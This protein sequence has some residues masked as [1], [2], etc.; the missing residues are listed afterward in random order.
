[1]RYLIIFAHP[2]TNSFNHAIKE[3]VENELTLSGKKFSSR[4]LYHMNFD[5][6]LNLQDI[7]GAQHGVV[8]EDVEEEQGYIRSA[9]VLIFIFPIWWGSMPAILKGYFDR[10]FSN[11]FAYYIDKNGNISGLLKD[12]KA[13]VINTTAASQDEY[14]ANGMIYNMNKILHDGLFDF[15]GIKLLEHQYLCGI[16]GTSATERERILET[17]RVTVKTSMST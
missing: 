3:V 10:V 4:D 5:P 2:N 16:H 14:T 17:I 11:T 8:L 12:K 13:I 9:D 6:V 7:D 15:C 1:M